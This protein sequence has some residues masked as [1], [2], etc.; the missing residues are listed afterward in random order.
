MLESSQAHEHMYLGELLV[1]P[2]HLDSRVIYYFANCDGE[3]DQLQVLGICDSTG[4]D[5]LCHN[6]VCFLG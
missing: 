3:S 6:S 5:P 1:D 2:G 4:E